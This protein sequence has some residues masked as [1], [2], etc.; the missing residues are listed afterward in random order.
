MVSRKVVRTQ[1]HAPL[2]WRQEWHFKLCTY[3]FTWYMVFALF[4]FVYVAQLQQYFSD[5][6]LHPD[7]QTMFYLLS[8]LCQ[9]L[10][11]SFWNET[12]EHIFFLSQRTWPYSNLN[13][14]PSAQQ[15]S[16]QANELC[17]KLRDMITFVNY[18]VHI[19]ICTRNRLSYSNS[20]DIVKFPFNFKL[21][22]L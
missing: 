20:T 12:P 15:F 13:P 14:Q 5:I 19:G 6:K 8:I 1:F 9:W 21:F 7:M 22:H 16:I 18:V 4:F 3:N 11:F 10:T 17:G 2:L